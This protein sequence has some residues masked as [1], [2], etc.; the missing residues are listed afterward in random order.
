MYHC[1]YYL[2]Y[3]LIFNSN[4]I[5]LKSKYPKDRFNVVVI[6][7]ILTE[8][9]QNKTINAK[10]KKI[11]YTLN[12]SHENKIFSAKKTITKRNKSFNVNNNNKNLSRNEGNTHTKNNIS[13]IIIIKSN[14][15]SKQ[16]TKN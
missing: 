15:K 6:N 3:F 16:K 10:S 1:E 2:L 14:N 9:P 5:S 8:T 7:N 11:N 12:N 4:D 13:I